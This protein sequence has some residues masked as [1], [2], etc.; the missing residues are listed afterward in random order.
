MKGY[1]S[2]KKYVLDKLESELPSYLTYHGIHHTYDVMNVCEQYIRRQALSKEDRYLLRIGAIVHDMGFLVS[3]VDH[4][5]VGAEMASAIMEQLEMEKDHIEAVKSLVM[6]TK[7]PQQPHNKLQ[8]IICDADLDYLGRKDY[9]ETSRMLFEELKLTNVL[10]TEEE[11]KT[12][13]IDF[14]QAHRFHTPFAIKNREPQK[15]VWL[16]SLL[17]A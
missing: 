16:Q 1:R 6:A 5:E 15:Q 2:I 14:L 9:P 3:P 12:L 11:W 13:Q 10:S 7:I 17:D 4:E 8:Q